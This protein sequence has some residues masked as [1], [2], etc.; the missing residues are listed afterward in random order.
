VSKSITTRWYIGAWIVAVLT[1][2][3]VGVMSRGAAGSSP[4]PAATILGVVIV[5]CGLVMLVM[6]I[7]ALIKLGQQHS[8]GWFAFVLLLYLL[9]LGIL[10][11]VAMAVYA[12]A[13]PDDTAPAVMRPTT[14]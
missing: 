8:W 10:G 7:G 4:P 9:T 13:G 12:I 2:I 5:L 11:I 6:W 1:G 14:T 3:V